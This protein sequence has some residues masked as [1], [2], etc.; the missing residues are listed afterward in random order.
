MEDQQ[1][2]CYFF[3]FSSFVAIWLFESR[4]FAIGAFVIA[5]MLGYF[6]DIAGFFVLL[7]IVTISLGLFEFYHG[8]R[9]RFNYLLWLSIV[10]LSW[11]FFTESL[12]EQLSVFDG[13][14]FYNSLEVVHYLNDNFSRM[15]LCLVICLLAIKPI[16]KVRA[17]WLLIQKTAPIS[18]VALLA[19]YTI[20][21]FSDHFVYEPEVPEF[22]ALW[23][24]TNFF[25]SSLAQEA[26]FRL[27]IMA[28]L[29][30]FSQHIPYGALVSLI[31]SAAIYATSFTFESWTLSMILFLKGLV[32]GLLFIRC[33]RIEISAMLNTAINFLNVF[34][35]T[36][37]A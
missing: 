3:L 20:Y 32:L 13:L 16:G 5:L 10:T 26:F 28:N 4:A 34:V 31:S 17:L 27:L 37:I 15:C 21:S 22:W 1:L 23:L 9:Y 29:M 30:R 12:T 36:L 14:W 24:V 6:Y 18:V 35:F 2:F 25:V 19:F 8:Q 33:G 7:F 11:L